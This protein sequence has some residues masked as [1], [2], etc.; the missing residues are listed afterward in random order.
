VSTEEVY[1]FYL[2]I[3]VIKLTVVITEAHHYFEPYT[4]LN[5]IFFPYG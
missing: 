4:K 1:H 3:R 2:F 5:P